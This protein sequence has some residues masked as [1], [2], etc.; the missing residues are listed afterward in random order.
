M[1]FWNASEG[2]NAFSASAKEDFFD[3]WQ[4]CWRDV[5]G[6]CSKVVLFDV[7][8]LGNARESVFLVVIVSFPVEKKEVSGGSFTENLFRV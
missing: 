3:F 4:I 2:G 7:K 1:E 5:S 6:E 8:F